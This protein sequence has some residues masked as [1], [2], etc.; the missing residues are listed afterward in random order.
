MTSRS[1]LGAV[2][3]VDGLALVGLLGDGQVG[4]VTGHDAAW[5]GS[6]D[7]AVLCKVGDGGV[8]AQKVLVEEQLA[9]DAGGRGGEDGEDGV[10]EDGG[11]AEV[12]LLGGVGG[13]ELL[14]GGGF[15][16]LRESGG[17]GLDV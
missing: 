14:G 5:Q 4:Q 12:V 15:D 2:G 17:V 1:K 11:L 9:V 3:A 6:R 13:G 16:G 7:E 8:V 10:G